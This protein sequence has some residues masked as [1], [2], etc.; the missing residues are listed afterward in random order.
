MKTKTQSFLLFILIFV[1][2]V[3]GVKAILEASIEK[4]IMSKDLDHIM[5]LKS[6]FKETDILVP[7]YHF[8]SDNPYDYTAVEEYAL[9]KSKQGPDWDGYNIMITPTKLSESECFQIV[10]MASGGKNRDNTPVE[11]RVTDVR[12]AFNEGDRRPRGDYLEVA[13]V[14]RE[15]TTLYEVVGYVF[16]TADD[17]RVERVKN[18]LSY[19]LSSLQQV[20][21]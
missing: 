6:Y 12:Q 9:E 20:E 4:T 13:A 2:S 1:L 7:N 16:G 3:F 11:W 10:V 17:A 8:Q 5:E 18:E 21:D 14:F 19:I 15:A